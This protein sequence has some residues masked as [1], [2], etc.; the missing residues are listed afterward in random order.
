MRTYNTPNTGKFRAV[1]NMTTNGGND[2][3]NQFIISFD[4]ARIFQSYQSVIVLEK[5]WQIYLG[6][7]WN[8]SNTTTQ[9]RNEFLG[10]NTA[11]TRKKLESGEYKMLKV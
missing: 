8:Y 5:E 3:P 11:E 9:Y 6:Q 4:K 10:E 1:R 2:A 7:D